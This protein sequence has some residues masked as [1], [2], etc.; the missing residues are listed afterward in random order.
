VEGT[1]D[2]MLDVT[3]TAKS[4][5]V[6][7][8][9]ALEAAKG[10]TVRLNLHVTN[11]AG[12]RVR[13]IADGKAMDGDAAIASAAQDVP[14]AWT[15]DG[16]RHWIRAEVT[17]ANGKLWLVGNPVYINWDIANGCGGK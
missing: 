5:A 11:S 4:G 3:A 1:R 6:H 10:E 16:G 13:W 17:D 7:A 15:N 12:G 2:R 14:L 9:D 8:G